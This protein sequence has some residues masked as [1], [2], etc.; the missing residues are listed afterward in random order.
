M[1]E[2]QKLIK[3]YI[4]FNIIVNFCNQNVDFFYAFLAICSLNCYQVNY[5]Y[6]G[7]AT[8]LTIV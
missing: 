3:I 6:F 7:P 1:L 5:L 8:F 4:F 2:Y